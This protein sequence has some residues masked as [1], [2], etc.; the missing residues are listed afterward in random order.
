MN[1]F[2]THSLDCHPR[3]F[4]IFLFELFRQTA[5]VLCDL[6]NAEHNRV[7]QQIVVFDFVFCFSFGVFN[8][9]PQVRD[10]FFKIVFIV[11]LR[12]P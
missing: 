2:V 3:N 7:D 10:D 11:F 4:A 8:Y 5:V 12:Y 9:E 6:N 1:Y